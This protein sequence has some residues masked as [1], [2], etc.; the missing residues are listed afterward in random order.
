V[1]KFHRP[2]R[3]NSRNAS[4]DLHIGADVPEPTPQ[5]SEVQM[6]YRRVSAGL[7]GI[8]LTL[9]ACSAAIGSAVGQLALDTDL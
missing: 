7:L 6:L 9:A 2:V 4:L 1:S 5:S 3:Q 8:V